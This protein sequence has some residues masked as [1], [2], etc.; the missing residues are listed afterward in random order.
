MASKEHTYRDTYLDSDG[1]E[2]DRRLVITE[3]QGTD[4]SQEACASATGLS[5]DFEFLF[6]ERTDDKE[7]IGIPIDTS[8]A[9]S[10]GVVA[11]VKRDDV[12][13]KQKKVESYALWRTFYAYPK[14]AS[15]EMIAS[16]REKMEEELAD[17]RLQNYTVETYKFGLPFAVGKV[18][19]ISTGYT[20]KPKMLKADTKKRKKDETSDD[21]EGD[22]EDIEYRPPKVASIRGSTTSACAA[23]STASR[24]TSG[25]GTSGVKVETDVIYITDVNEPRTLRSQV[26]KQKK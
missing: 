9:Q 15:D 2:Q 22:G 11:V 16:I 1:E 12:H 4:N 19:R 5:Q 17:F 26:K 6:N 20:G 18:G 14:D 23:A 25:T 10:I 7:T 13:K 24:T 21:D 8:L 3:S